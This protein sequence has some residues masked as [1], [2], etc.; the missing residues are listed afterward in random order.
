MIAAGDVF[1]ADWGGSY[2]VHR[3]AADQVVLADLARPGAY[4]TSTAAELAAVGGKFARVAT[5]PPIVS[6][7]SPRPPA[8]EDIA[9]TPPRSPMVIKRHPPVP[10]DEACAWLLQVFRGG[11]YS[12]RAETCPR[13]CPRSPDYGTPAPRAY[14]PIPPLTAAELAAQRAVLAYA[15]GPCSP[16]P[17]PVDE[18]A[19]RA[20]EVAHPA[21]A[22]LP[23]AMLDEVDEPGD[24][25]A[26]LAQVAAHPMDPPPPANA[27]DDCGRVRRALAVH[28]N[29]LQFCF[30]CLTPSR[31]RTEQL[32]LAAAAAAARTARPRR[33]GERGDIGSFDPPPLVERWRAHT[34]EVPR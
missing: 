24:L 6:A 23:T 30:D 25:D 31:Q 27:C 22:R 16:P 29:G 7:A 12:C 5:A 11:R 2:R 4:V 10:A 33:G 8:C 34:R 19:A 32:T 1:N 26:E 15:L 17:P 28:A 9:R 3:I 18:S 13:A 20:A 14:A 21:A